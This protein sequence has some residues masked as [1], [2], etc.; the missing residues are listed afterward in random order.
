MGNQYYIC[1]VDDY[2]WHVHL[3]FLKLKTEAVQKIKDYLTS[4]KTNN[5]QLHTIHVDG[6]GEFINH[7]LREWC[8]RQGIEIT[9]LLLH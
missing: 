2:M 7:E 8:Q 4:L 9:G 3:R 1:F 5:K 6:G